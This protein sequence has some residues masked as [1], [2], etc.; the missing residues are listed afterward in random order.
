MNLAANSFEPHQAE[1][2]RNVAHFGDLTAQKLDAA[3]KTDPYVN[4]ADF[5]FLVGRGSLSKWLERRI[6]PM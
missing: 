6:L 5:E 4:L 2:L 3:F 1:R